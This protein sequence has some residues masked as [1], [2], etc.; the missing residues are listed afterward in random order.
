MAG[1]FR[2]NAKTRGAAMDI[3]SQRQDDPVAIQLPKFSIGA[4][5]EPVQFHPARSRSEE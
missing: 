1:V 2:V 3:H 5:T 4:D